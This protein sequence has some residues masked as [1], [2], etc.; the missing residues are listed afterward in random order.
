M[1]AKMTMVTNSNFIFDEGSGR[2]AGFLKQRSGYTLYYLL[3]QEGITGVCL[4]DS[5]LS[6]RSG[7]GISGK[8]WGYVM[9]FWI[10]FML[11]KQ[12]AKNLHKSVKKFPKKRLR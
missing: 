11:H 3:K 2:D 4:Y 8:C 9:C 7:S 5:Y 1:A 10:A 12:M 6:G